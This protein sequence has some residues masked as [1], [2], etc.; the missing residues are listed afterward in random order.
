MEKIVKTLKLSREAKQRLEWIIYYYT[1]ANKNTSLICRHFGITRS[2][3]YFWINRFNEENL[4][5][6]EN[7]STA[8]INKRQ[9][10]YTHLQY[11]RIVRLRKEFIRYR[12]TKLFKKYQN[13]YPTD[14]SISEWKVQ[15]I[16]QILEIILSS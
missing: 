14:K 15:S 8:P 13:L 5:T 11:E 6:L 2:K 1:K 9:K 3:W 12:K 16:I 10:E 7:N 4:R